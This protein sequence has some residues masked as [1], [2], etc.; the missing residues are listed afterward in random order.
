MQDCP[1]ITGTVGIY[2]PGL[3]KLWQGKQQG[4]FT[5]SIASSVLIFSAVKH[6][7]AIHSEWHPIALANRYALQC[8]N[9][10]CGGCTVIK[11]CMHSLSWHHNAARCNPTQNHWLVL[12][13]INGTSLHH[14]TKNSHTTTNRWCERVLFTGHWQLALP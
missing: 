10:H 6:G 13:R 14:H 4:P 11:S 12:R 3:L 9:V 1:D 5:P 2:K 8:T 7:G